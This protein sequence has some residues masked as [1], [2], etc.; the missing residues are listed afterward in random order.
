[1][2]LARAAWALGFGW[3]ECEGFWKFGSED[4]VRGLHNAF[5]KVALFQ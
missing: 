4:R 3:L 5:R 1:M 2:E